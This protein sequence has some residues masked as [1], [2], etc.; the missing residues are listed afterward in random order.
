M[1]YTIQGMRQTGFHEWGFV[2]YRCAYGDDDLWDRYIAALKADVYEGLD[3]NGRGSLEPF[4]RWT[5]VQDRE[6]LDGA[7]KALVRG[8]FAAWRDQHAVSRPQA[9]LLASLV[10][11][12]GEAGPLLPRFTCC[13]YVDQKCLA[14]LEAHLSGKAARPAPGL[15][16]PPPPLVAVAVD[17]DF[18]G[19]DSDGDQGARGH[20]PVDG[21]TDYY[22]G[23]QYCNTLYLASLYD[24]LHRE[25]LSSDYKRP[26][27]I[28][29]SGLKSMDE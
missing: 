24:K 9:S 14:T 27:A 23:W 7:P 29:P 22:V 17:G 5:V 18:S 4:V 28:A 20:P 26:P 8:R 21:C 1:G 16:R 2:I 13:L 15:G 25:K 19:D 12:P 11:L 10:P 3:H 6:A